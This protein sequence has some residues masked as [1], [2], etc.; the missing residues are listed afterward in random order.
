MMIQRYRRARDEVRVEIIDVV[1]SLREANRRALEALERSDAE[2]LENSREP[3]KNFSD[4]T[5]K[6]DNDI[7]RIFVKFSPEARDLREM[8]SYLKD[9]HLGLN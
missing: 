3:I 6:I 2:A 7:V 4:R 5:E 1:K 8:V 9:N